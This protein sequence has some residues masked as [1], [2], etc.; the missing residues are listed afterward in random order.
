MRSNRWCDATQQ[1]PYSRWRTELRRRDVGFGMTNQYGTTVD[2]MFVQYSN[3]QTGRPICEAYKNVSTDWFAEFSASCMRSTRL[4]IVTLTVVD[5]SFSVNDAASL[6]SCCG[7]NEILGEIAG[8]PDAK[9]AKYTYV[10]DCCAQATKC[11]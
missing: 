11:V 4:S 2:Y 3:P 8:T 5:S 1:Q 9:I 10:L 6:P 7:D